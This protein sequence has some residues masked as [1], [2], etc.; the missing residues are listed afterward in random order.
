MDDKYAMNQISE[1]MYLEIRSRFFDEKKQY[2]AKIKRLKK[3][4][5]DTA[6]FIESLVK[7]VEN[8][9]QTYE[10][11]TLEEKSR[12]LKAIQVK[13]F[14]DDAGTLY[15]KENPMLQALGFQGCLSNGKS[16][17][18]IKLFSFDRFIISIK[19]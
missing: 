2:E 5:A 3:E 15:V 1:D 7:L 12:I 11:G 4:N 6:G 9:D 13:L 10:R 18:S 17:I 8:L 19:G 16:E 14:I